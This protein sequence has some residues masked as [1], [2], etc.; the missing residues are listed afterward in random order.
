MAS[1]EEFD[2]DLQ[3]DPQR[4]GLQFTE[5]TNR[6]READPIHWS[7][8]SQAWI[9]TRHQD[10]SDGFNR[11]YPLNNAGRQEFSLLA[12]PHDQRQELIPNLNSYVKNWIV[13]TD[14]DQHNRLRKLIMAAFTKKQVERVRPLARTRIKELLDFVDSRNG[15]VEFNEEV[16]RPLP[17]YVLF[18]L[19]GIPDSHLASLRDWSNAVVEGMT[20][21]APSLELLQKT[22]WAMGEMNRV[23]IEELEKRKTDPQDDLFTTLLNATVDGDKLTVDELLSAMHILIV[24]G[25]DTTSNTM[26]MGLEALSRHPEAWKFMHENPDRMLDCVN[27]IM[28]YI[29]MSSGQP[30]IAAEDFEWHGKQIKQGQIVFLSIQGA[31]RDPRVFKNPETLDFSRDNAGS[32]VFAPGLHHCIGHLLAKMQLV[33]FF[34]E[35][36]NRYESVDILDKELAF[37]PVGIFRG[38]YGMNVRLNARK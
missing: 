36:V 24:A 4:H 18:K 33:E 31:N 6:L 22:D 21:S 10:V 3:W 26:T 37:M 30:R 16:A 38:L 8:K 15:E 12:V 27:E 1:A 9:V 20:V 13:M 11:V 23:V 17:G 32:Q 5:D 19:V 28:R 34:T 2:I 14:G 29:A 7:E 25:H 35:L